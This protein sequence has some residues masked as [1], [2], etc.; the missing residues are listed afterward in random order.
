VT[1]SLPVGIRGL[2]ALFGAC[3]LGLA[4]SFV[5]ARG[6]LAQEVPTTTDPVTTMPSEPPP[7]A[8]ITPAPK[9][10]PKPSPRTKTTAAKATPPAAVR[11]STPPPPA[12]VVSPASPPALHPPTDATTEP[13]VLRSARARSRA[14]PK[15]Q[16]TASARRK[17]RPRATPKPLLA[18]SVDHPVQPHRDARP[19]PGP[20]ASAVSAAGAGPRKVGGSAL[21]LL[22][23]LVGL[24]ALL[25]G[26]AAVPPEALANNAVGY[27]LVDRQGD[28]G[29]FGAAV[30][31]VVVC[32]LIVVT[33]AGL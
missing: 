18:A 25:I 26:T 32:M 8:T 24:S 13:R 12:T 17:R 19:L 28:L 3:A 33:V 31:A 30:L 7:P 23:G 15:P 9:P 2:A 4:V 14:K 20:A 10:D 29:L 16:P 1:R 11:R 27:F 21:W 6:S 5:A 22:F